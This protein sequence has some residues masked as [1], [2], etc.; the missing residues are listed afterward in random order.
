M[1]LPD[2]Q[3]T[4]RM[5]A[6]PSD[7]NSAGDVFGG[8]IMAQVDMA[9][10]ILAHQIADGRVATISVNAFV[11][12]EPIFVGDVVSCFATNNRV[13]NTSV[14]I[15]IEVFAERDHSRFEC[16]KVTEASLTYVAID[17]NRKPRVIQPMNNQQV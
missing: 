17:K 4:L 9:G 7:T 8:W 16:L 3:A 10:S 12:L 5:I 6:M 14:T 11:F 2:K 15:D 13:G 1:K